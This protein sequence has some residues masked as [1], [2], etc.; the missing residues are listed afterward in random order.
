MKNYQEM[1]DMEKRQADRSAARNSANETA[2]SRDA[3]RNR[4]LKPIM[5][6]REQRG[7]GRVER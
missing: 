6:K 7:K 3:M 1:T 4:G 2:G 5:P